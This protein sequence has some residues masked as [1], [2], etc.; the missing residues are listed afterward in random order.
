MSLREAKKKKNKRAI[1]NSAISL[2]NENGYDHTSIEQIARKAGVGKGTVYSYFNNKKSIIKGFCEYELEKIHYQLIAQSNR[3]ASVLEQMLIIYMTEFEHVTQNREFGRLYM[4]ES[5]FPD[6]ADVT[7]DLDKKYFDMLFP[8]LEKGQ[9]RGEL[10]KDLELLHI[11]AQFYSLFI[12]IISAWYTG[13]LPTSEV[14]IAMKM[15]FKQALEGL[16]PVPETHNTCE[17]SND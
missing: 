11:T 12:I 16:C 2:F 1:L 14:A 10:R 15:L 7:T 6:D 5:L 13:R 17:N 3:E 9:E 4:R 8:I